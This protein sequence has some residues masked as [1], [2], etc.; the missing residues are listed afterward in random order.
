MV[1]ITIQLALDRFQK[2][3]YNGIGIVQLFKVRF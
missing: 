2:L 1:S 3:L